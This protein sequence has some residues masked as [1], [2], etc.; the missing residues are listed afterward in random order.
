MQKKSVVTEDDLRSLFGDGISGNLP[1]YANK[2]TI[3]NISVGMKVWGVVSEVNEKDL[4]ISLPGGLRGL[5]RASEAFDPVLDNENK[6]VA[7]SLLP[8]VFHTG[9]LVSCIV[10]KLDE[11]NKEK[12][13][14]KIWLSLH[15]SLLHK[16]FTLESV[17]EGM[18]LTAYVKSIEDHGY[19]LHFGLSSFT[20]FLPKHRESDSKEIQV[21]TGQLLQ[22]VVESVDK[23]RK[24]V[25]LIS[26]QETVSKSV[27]KD[28]KGISIDL[29]VPGMM[30]N[31]RLLSTLENGVMLSFITYFTGTVNARILFIDPSTRA[32]GLT[33]NPHLVHSKAPTSSVKIG[34]ICDASKVVWV[35]RGLGLL[36]EIP[37]T[38]VPTP[39]YYV[40]ISD[41]AE[42]DARKLEKKFKQGSRVRVRILGF[43]HL[44]GLATGTLKG[45]ICNLIETG[46]FVRFL[47]RL[48]GFSPRHKAMDD[49]KTDLS[50]T[51]FIGQSVR[52][53]VNSETGRITLSLKQLS[54]SSTDSSFIQEYF[55]F[56]EKIATL[57]LLDS[58][59]SKSNWLEGFTLGTVVE[60]KVQEVKD[61]GVV[62]S[63]EQYNDV[64]GFIT[65]YQLGVTVVETGSSIHAVV[66]DVA[67]AEH[68]VDLSMKEE[69]TNK[70]KENSNKKSHK[71]KRKSEALDDL[72]VHQTVNAVVE[73]VKENYLVLSIPKYNYAVGYASISDYNTQ[74][75]LQKQFLN[76]QREVAFTLK[77]ISES[78]T[79]SSKRAKKKSNYKVGSMV[80]AE[81]TAVKPLELRLKFGIGFHGR[82]HITEVNDELLEDP[83]NKF[84]IGQTVTA[85][86]IGKTNYS[87]KNKKSY[88]WDLSLKPTML[89]GSCEIG[90]N[91][92]NEDLDFSTG[93]CVSGYVYK[94]DG[95]WV[96][97]TISRSV[98]AQLFILDSACE[99]GELKG[100]QKRFHLG[101][102][103]SGYVLSV[104][105]EKKLLRLVLHPFSP[106]SDK[107]V[108]HEVSKADDPHIINEN[109][110][111]H[112]REG[113]VI[114]GRI[115]KK[116]PG[117]S[118]LTVQIG[119]H[120][121]GRVHYTELSDSWE[122]DPLSGYH[123]G[124]FVKC[125]VLEL[126]CSVKGTFHIDLSLRA[127]EVGGLGSESV[128]PQDDKQTQTKRVEKI[129]DLNPNMV[130][131]GYVK[132]VTPKGCFILLSRK[133]DAKILVSNLSDGYV[134]DLEK[135]FPVGKLVTGR[136][137]SVEPLSKRVEVTLKSLN[138]SSVPQF[139]S[140]NL[141]SLHVG[142]IIS[143]RVKRMESYGLFITIDNTNMVGLC[144]MSE[145]SEDKVDNIETK[146]ETGERVTAKV[147][148]KK[149]GQRE[150]SSFSW[151]EGC[152]YQA[153]ND[154]ETPSEQDPDETIVENGLTDVTMSE[155]CPESNSFFT[156]DMDV[157]S[158]N[159]ESQFFAQAESRAFVPP[160]EVTLDDIDQ[161]NGEDKENLDVD[162][163]NEKKMQPTKKIA[164][165]ER[166]HEIRSAEER[167]LANDIPRTNEEY[168]KLVRTSPNSN[169]VWIKYM[170]FVLSTTNVEKARSIAE[171]STDYLFSVKGFG[172]IKLDK[173][174]EKEKLN[175]SPPEEA[176]RKVFQ[177]AVQC[178]DSRMVH[179]ALL[180]LYERTEQHRLAEELLN[181]MTKKFK[182]SCKDG[183][184][185]VISR[186]EKV[187]PKHKLIKFNSQ[188]AILE[189]KCGEPERWRSMFENILQNNPK[190]T[191]LWSVYLDQEI[192]LGNSDLI[193]ALFER[194]TSLSLPAKKMKFL[195]KKY[196]AYEKSRGDEEKI[197]YV[198]RKAM[199]YVENTVA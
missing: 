179:L 91:I 158:K 88:Q 73:M 68:L 87:D 43:R 44:E 31:A 49:H 25:Y 122:S 171:S 89:A 108:D 188:T 133:L 80:E 172:N 7:D 82:V 18:V 151:D 155:I 193:H 113:H 146:Y 124:Q 189:F 95:E 71:K 39:A 33:L 61:I 132:N 149:S 52:S 165:E 184:Q 162:T 115:I 118:G 117:V 15:L 170:Q 198:K 28:L 64:F 141:D 181:K 16:G 70:L 157:D 197:E 53:N 169:F 120:I 59:E 167:L 101:N 107:T 96:W 129:E 186:A 142:D 29:L 12:K 85:K 187:L 130:V 134:Q 51:Y 116:L 84:R 79:S 83:F 135:E 138:A 154:L 100:F 26:D 94:V 168:E 38:P 148:K 191:D 17:Q 103:V 37:S 140:N 41:V 32:V 27:T 62:I 105:R 60:G 102:A 144:H 23:I 14:R 66:L 127:S 74:K 45:Y 123:E 20:G 112:I 174:T 67:K 125:K 92:I 126:I 147:L 99:P 97:L 121:H 176:V 5:V 106:I 86:I 72:E 109:I 57:Q 104:N 46:Y 40:Y 3:K 145:L 48:T 111:A 139:G 77:S 182:T 81:I 50:E 114:G 30:V 69:F 55:M 128:E 131:Q 190:R 119:P 137:S 13:N 196:L 161:W 195:F 98:R 42:E 75:V 194:A 177:R 183:I 35:D 19:I 2:I 78:E 163:V 90:E 4:V 93:Q 9:Q 8:S 143:G 156:Q 152:L 164:K 178:N 160:L 166:E 136:V 63:F 175:G 36:L 153:N 22:G 34:D 76:G 192:R 21:K 24:V 110:T 65:H 1:K 173:E 6:A 10:L 185:D 47:G 58:E 56:E 11:D 54:C 150:A 159:A 199:E 180:G